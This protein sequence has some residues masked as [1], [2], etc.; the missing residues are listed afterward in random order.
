M[1]RR[2]RR[3][4]GYNFK[5]EY[6]KPKGIP[7]NLLQETTLSF[8]ELEVLRLRYIKKLDQTT[9]SKEMNI[10]QSQYQRDL[11]TALEKI[12]NALINGDAIKIEREKK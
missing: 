4:V 1:R 5:E 10:S 2:S 11:R 7:L 3:R 8:E 12:S 6:F 9:A